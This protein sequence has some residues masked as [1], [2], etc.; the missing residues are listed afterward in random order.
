MAETFEEG[1]T[2]YKE[3]RDT[4]HSFVR[5]SVRGTILV[6]AMVV[7]AFIFIAS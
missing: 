7:V 5:W 1:S 6:V 3:H 4:W 2:F